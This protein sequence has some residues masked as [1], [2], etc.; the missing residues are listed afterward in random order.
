VDEVIESDKSLRISQNQANIHFLVCDRSGK[1]ASI[2]FI[3]GKFVCHTDGTLPSE[4]LTNSTYD[5]SLNYLK[6][7]ENNGG[8]MAPAN[9]N[10]SMD[11]FARL[12]RAIKDY[13][14]NPPKPIVDSAFDALSSVSVESENHATQWSIVYD[15]QKR[16]IAFKTYKN[17]QL[18]TLNIDDFNYS[19]D[20]PTQILSIEEKL[21]GKISGHFADYTT[22]RNRDLIQSVF[23]R[24]KSV[25]FM[26]DMPNFIIEIMATYPESMKCNH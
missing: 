8:E 10:E 12:S 17:A 16:N 21:D 1:V 14:T 20:T 6:E 13:R 2:E 23:A 9:F 26:K 24:Y 3:E 4:V 11:R 15:L 22:D 18:R 5:K 7:M 25:G 19:C